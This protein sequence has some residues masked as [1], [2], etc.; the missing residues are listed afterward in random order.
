MSNFTDN[1][2]AFKIL[3]MLTTPF[4]KTDAYKYGIIDKDGN[5]LKKLKD[6]KK[7]EEKDSYTALHRLVFNLKRLIALAPGGSSYVGNLIAA[8]YLIKENRNSTIV[9]EDDFN[10][11][12]QSIERG[13]HFIEEEMIVEDYFSLVEEAPTNAVGSGAAVSTDYPAIKKKVTKDE[14]DRF[15]FKRNKKIPMVG[16]KVQ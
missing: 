5:K 1:L 14:I 8:Y 11:V 12:L 4:E 10:A 13:V 6:L 15:M 7:S 16:V 9:S 3:Y 2:I